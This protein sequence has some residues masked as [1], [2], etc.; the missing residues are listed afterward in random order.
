[1][2]HASYLMRQIINIA[3]TALP[4]LFGLLL[5]VGLL[6]FTLD[7]VPPMKIRLAT[8]Q[9]NASYDKVGQTYQQ[10]L[11]AHDIAV[12]LI[13]SNGSL[14]NIKLLREGKA[15]VA[16][17]QNAGLVAE[18][19]DTHQID[20]LGLMFRQPLW[21]IYRADAPEISG[22]MKGR[23]PTQIDQILTSRT[24]LGPEGSGGRALAKRL[25]DELRLPVQPDWPRLSVDAAV[26]AL[27]AGQIDSA[28]FVASEDAPA[29]QKLFVEMRRK[30]SP[31]R[32]LNLAN[33]EGFTL[34]IAHLGTTVLPR[35]I[36][37]FNDNV[38]DQDI[39]LLSTTTSVLVREDLHPAVQNLLITTAQ[40][41]HQPWN[42]FQKEGEFP[43]FQ[44]SLFHLSDE[45]QRYALRGNMPRWH[46]L[47]FWLANLFDRSWLTLVALMAFLLPASRMVPP[48]YAWRIRRRIFRWY[49]D[50]Y[51]IEE[52]IR[53]KN[54][55][56]RS[57]RIAL[58][59]LQRRV[60]KVRIPISRADELYRLRSHIELVRQRVAQA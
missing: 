36:L 38:P 54:K 14:D 32:L 57:I 30:D 17:V 42:W 49:A 45:A 48:I 46:R 28:L 19:R 51:L 1:M 24:S 16:I 33:A 5:L 59:E 56:T 6:F 25:L 58:D 31:V 37:N 40:R 34:N 8:G 3:W 47:P 53:K 20:S 26:N 50:L 35:G 39:R 60:E 2:K 52:S 22:R 23:G 15:D 11:A 12:E 21:I 13:R 29:L 27:V 7:P 43:Q 4:L 9:L 55:T 10:H 41:I 18:L 44:P